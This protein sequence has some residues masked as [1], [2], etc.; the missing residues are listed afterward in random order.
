MDAAHSNDYC[1]THFN[2]RQHSEIA[3]EQKVSKFCMYSIIR[4][5][6]TPAVVYIPAVGCVTMTRCARTVIAVLHYTKPCC[7][8]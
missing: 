3:Q 7:N 4:L 5:L 2:S 1:I 8:I 6:V